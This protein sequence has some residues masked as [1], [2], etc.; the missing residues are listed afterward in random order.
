MVPSLTT[1]TSS[2]DCTV[3]SRCAITCIAIERCEH[4][5]LWPQVAVNNS[6]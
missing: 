1:A 3:L 5:L 6:R 2:A 4:L